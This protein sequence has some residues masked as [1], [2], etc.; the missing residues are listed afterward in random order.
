VIEPAALGVPVMF[1]PAHGNAREAAALVAA[2]GG[3]VISKAEDI[4]DVV[5]VWLAEDGPGRAAAEF[6]VSRAGGAERN[7]RIILDF[8]PVDARRAGRP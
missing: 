3:A 4:G 1:G 5:R 6:V 8:L 7:A 2:G